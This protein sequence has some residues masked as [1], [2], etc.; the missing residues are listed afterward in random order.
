MRSGML[1]PLIGAAIVLMAGSARAEETGK[2]PDFVPSDRWDVSVKDGTATVASPTRDATL[3]IGCSEGDPSIALMVTL[4]TPVAFS[5][6]FRTVTMVFDGGQPVSQSW[7]STKDSYGITE[8]ELAFPVTIEGL[9]G[10]RSVE[11]VL[12]EDGKELDRHSFTLNGATD[13]I[14]SVVRTCHRNG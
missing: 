7:F 13:A 14:G 11:F 6:Q 12:S 8:D 3:L 1:A 4:M 2:V 5:E 9:I 10:H